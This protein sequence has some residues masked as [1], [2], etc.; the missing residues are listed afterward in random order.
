MK[1]ILL[2]VAGFV[3]ISAMPAAATADAIEDAIKA[4]KSF[5][6]V[7]AFNLSILGA[8]AKGERDYDAELARTLSKNLHALSL[9]NNGAMWPEGSGNDKPALT[10]KTRALPAIWTNYPAVAEKHKAWTDAS[11]DLAAT[12]GDGLEVLK[13]KMGPVGK[14]CGGCHKDFRAEKK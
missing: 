10:D 6:Q 5:M 12:A 4:R 14:S 8:M 1:A 2:A 13:S 3:A 9:L 11:A 7:S